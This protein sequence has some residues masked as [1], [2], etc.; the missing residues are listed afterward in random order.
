MPRKVSSAARLCILL[1]RNGHEAIPNLYPTLPGQGEEVE[2][3]EASFLK[4]LQDTRLLE[5]DSIACFEKVD[6]NNRLI[7]Y[8]LRPPKISLY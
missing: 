5:Q 3:M 8:L 4:S 1:C 2:A 6:W 7:I